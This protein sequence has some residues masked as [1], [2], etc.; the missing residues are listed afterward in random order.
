[1]KHNFDASLKYVLAHEGGFVNHPADP[2]GMT[3]LGVTKAVWEEWIGH[4][5]DEKAMRALTPE[6]VSPMYKRRYWDK[7][8]CNDLPEGI[9]Y[10]VFDTAVNSGPGRAIKLLQGCVNA[11]VDGLLGP[12]TLAA[13]KAFDRKQLIQDYAKRRLSYLTE[14]KNWPVFGKGWGNRVN[15]VEQISLKMLQY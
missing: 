4:P 9:D 14:L 11:D 10:F 3:N 15:R 6:M 8:G 1:M 5:V 13:V 2:G 12:E 7:A